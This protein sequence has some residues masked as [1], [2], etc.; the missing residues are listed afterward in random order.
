MEDEG[1]VDDSFIEETAWEY[2]SLHGRECVTLLRRLA[3]AG[4][5]AGDALSAQTWRAI[6]EAAERIINLD[7][8]PAP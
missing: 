4:Q 5:R 1:F 6:A 3:D 8:P 2:V 7:Q